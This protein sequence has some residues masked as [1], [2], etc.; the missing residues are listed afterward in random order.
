MWQKESDVTRDYF[1][2]L[3]QRT[4]YSNT[5]HLVGIEANIG[6]VHTSGIASVIQQTF[7]DAGVNPAQLRF[8]TEV[9]SHVDTTVRCR[10]HRCCC[11]CTTC[12]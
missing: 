10:R 4:N 1:E 9:P 11:C 7:L 3:I 8:F 2:A 6:M 12:V 5:I